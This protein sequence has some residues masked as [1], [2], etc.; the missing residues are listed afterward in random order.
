[1]QNTWQGTNSRHIYL[2]HAATTPVRKEVVGAMQPFWGRYYGNPSSV[3]HAGQEARRALENARNIIAESL[4]A[5]AGEIIFTGCGSESDNL[6]LRGVMWA[7][8]ATGRGN[9][10]ITCAIEHKAVLETAQQLR[11]LQGFDLT[12]LP[13]IKSG[14]IDLAELEGSI[15]PDTVLISIMAANNE[16]GTLLPLAEIGQL[17]QKHGVLF[18][19]D[20]VQAAALTDWDMQAMPIDLLSLSAHK[21]YGPKGIGILYARREVELVPALS[22]GAQEDGRRAGTANVPGAVGAAE[23][24]R[25]AMVERESNVA[26]Y[27]KLR[28]RLIDG[29]M[30]SIA[31]DCILTGHPVERLA[32][33]ASFAF[34]NVDGNDLVV[35][36]DLAG[37]GASSGSACLTGDSEP[38][39]VLQ[40]MGLDPKWTL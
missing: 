36:L 3:H 22:G 28:D 18:H 2:D 14:R 31:D 26:K 30:E 17:A 32:N 39:A 8:R 15:R 37:I 34:K 25:L 5:T 23:A 20:A 24:L 13:V 29:I 33:H 40:A 38:S 4:N 19:T 10:L 11:D 12:I 9:H 16:V 6:A 35:H 27:C 7:A 21:F 1:M